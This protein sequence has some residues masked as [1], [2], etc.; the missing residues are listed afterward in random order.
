MA[1]LG[2]LSSSRSFRL[3]DIRTILSSLF[4]LV[5]CMDVNTG[6]QVSIDSPSIPSEMLFYFAANQSLHSAF[7]V[8]VENDAPKCVFFSP[9][10]VDP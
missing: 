10:N 3:S 8:N 4:V 1:A 5:V 6:L 7:L 9:A 2:M